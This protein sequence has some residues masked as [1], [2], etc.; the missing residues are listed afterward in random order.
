MRH[1][2]PFC[3]LIAC[4]NESEL[5]KVTEDGP[6]SEVDWGSWDLST[7]FISQSVTCAGMGANGQGL[8]NLFAEIEVD[9]PDKIEVLLGTRQ[10][11]G[12][13]EYNTFR[14]DSFDPIPVENTDGYGIGVNLEAEVL[15]EH[16]FTGELTYE[17]ISGSG[18]CEILIGVTASWL[19]YEPPPPC[20]S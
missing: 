16:N 20:N 7:T 19:Y 8:G 5:P 9:A 17:I 6:P 14:A 4:N 11:Q 12:V 15:D 18:I 3:L 2:L 10:L 13:R 1:L